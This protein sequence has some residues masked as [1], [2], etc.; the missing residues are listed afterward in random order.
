VTAPDLCYLPAAEAL[1]LFRARELSPVELLE[2]VPA[3]ADEVEPVV[4]A[5]CHRFPERALRRAR[6]AES[7]YAGKG[8]PPRPLEG[9]PTAVK[10]EEPIEGLPWT[11]GSRVHADL[12]A[13][14]TSVFARRILD[15]GAVVHAMTTAPEFS[16]ACFTHSALWGVTRNPWNPDVST[17]GSSGGSAAALASGTTTLASG[18]DIGGS[19]RVP[20]A[21]CGVVGFKPPFGRVPQ[22][23]PFNRTYD[24]LT[25]FRVGA[26]CERARPWLDTRERRPLQAP[27]LPR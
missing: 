1:R 11:Q 26:A 15:A 7:R 17:G 3:R 19:I 5:L 20:A 6:E 9:I 12:V 14:E 2:S 27:S 10:E 16:C 23:A 4:N 25:A 21:F 13:D 24:D 22:L 8:D 18:S